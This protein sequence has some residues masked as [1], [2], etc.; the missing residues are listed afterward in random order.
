M[1]FAWSVDG[2]PRCRSC[3]CG[4]CYTSSNI[5]SFF[6]AKLESV[7]HIVEVDG[8]SQNLWRR[9]AVSELD[10]EEARDGDHLITPFQCDI[11]VFRR[12]K[13]MDPDVNSHSDTL[14]LSYIRRANLDAFWSRA[15]GTIKNNK[16][17]VDRTIEGFSPFGCSVHSTI[18]VLHLLTITQDMKPQWPC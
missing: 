7:E 16:S 4:S 5:V 10:Y 15:R 1:N 17:T 2:F 11:C 14:T 6:K 8:K 12:I 9:K 18:E 13:G 3:W